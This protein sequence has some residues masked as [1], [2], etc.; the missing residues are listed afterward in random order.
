[1]MTVQDENEE[2]R[3]G[4][5]EESRGGEDEESRGGE[6]EES[7]GG[8]DEES[9]GGENEKIRG[10][11]RERTGKK[12]KDK[13]RQA[14][15]QKEG[16]LVSGEGLSGGKTVADNER[17]EKEKTAEQKKNDDRRQSVQQENGKRMT[18]QKKSFADVMSQWKVRKARGFMGDSIIRK[19]DKVVYRGEDITRQKIEDVAE[20]AGQVMGGGTGGAV[21]VHVGTNKAEKEGTPAIVGKYR[22]L[23]KTLEQAR[24]GQIL[25]VMGC[26]VKEN[27]NCRRMAINT[28]VQKV[29]VEERDGFVDMWLNYVGRD[30]FFVRDGFHL[31]GKGIA[32]LGYE[33]VRVVDKGTYTVNYLNYKRMGNFQRK[34]KGVQINQ[35]P[36]KCSIIISENE[37]K[38]VCLNFRNI[39]NKKCPT[40][41]AP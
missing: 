3:G 36:M 17:R 41:T 21:L 40:Y 19:V 8:E 31:T 30:D 34:L 29:S 6:D 7:R 22:R 18:R 32:V 2:S 12:K 35:N 33:F 28:Q 25:P 13:R 15:Q 27:R 23:V 16:K 11:V 10:N 4:E 20:K 24:V 26:R 5:D 39:V 38:C 37:H 1:M 14:V 9:R